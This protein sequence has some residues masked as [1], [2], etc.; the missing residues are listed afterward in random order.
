MAGVQELIPLL[1][2]TIREALKETEPD[3]PIYR[4]AEG[5]VMREVVAKGDTEKY[6]LSRLDV[7]ESL[8][9]RV[10]SRESVQTFPEGQSPSYLRRI[11][12]LVLE[13]LSAE[14]SGLT[15]HELA[16]DIGMEYDQV[17][18][19]ISRLYHKGLG[20]VYISG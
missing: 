12:E 19:I 11:S 20:S 2:E 3:N 10:G 15:V 18:P 8:L 4:V 9:N 13:R 5:K 16:A 14:G 1:E 17:R 6:I 7:I